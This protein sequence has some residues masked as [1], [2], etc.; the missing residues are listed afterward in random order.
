MEMKQGLDIN[1]SNNVC[2]SGYKAIVKYLVE[3]GT[4][5][6]KENEDGETPL[7]EACINGNTEIVKYLVE[8]GADINKIDRFGRTPLFEACKNCNEETIKFLIE[9]KENNV[10]ET[11]LFY[12]CENGFEGKKKMVN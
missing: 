9:H 4:Y 3:Q 11:T 6:N 1:K 7:F 2:L 5:I 10:N 12:E 8:N